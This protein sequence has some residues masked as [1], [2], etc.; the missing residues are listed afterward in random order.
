MQVDL[1]AVERALAWAD[2]VVDLVPLQ[3]GFERCLR[4]V[5][6]LVGA[7]P[8]V[9]SRRELGVRCEAEQVVEVPGVFDHP[10]D[11][12]LDLLLHDEHMRVVLRDVP[13][14]QEAVQ[15]PAPLVSVQS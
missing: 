8:L 1:R 15:R 10:V 3:G 14:P 11:L 7:E 6:L 12:F 2:D 5:P 4:T 9:R 13:D